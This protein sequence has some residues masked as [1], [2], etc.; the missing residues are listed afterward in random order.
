MSNIMK[1]IIIV[2]FRPCKQ[3]FLSGMCL[4][5]SV[6]TGCSNDKEDLPP[7]PV[8]YT[9]LIYMIA[10]NSMDSDVDYSIS[11][12]KAGARHS[13]GTAVVYVDRLNE[14]PRLFKITQA[15]EEVPLKSYAEDNSANIETLVEVIEETKK[16][17]P[18]EKFGLV[19][20]S[21]SMGWLPNGYSSGLRMTRGKAEQDFP[22]TRYIGPDFHPGDVPTSDNMIEVDEL[23]E[24][25]PD[26]V[27]EYIWFDVCLMGCVEGL[28]AVRNKC[29]YLIASP[30][31]V[32]AEADYDASGIPYAKVL[33]YMF[34]GAEELKQACRADYNHYNGMKYDV[35]RSATITLVDAKQLDGLYD[36]VHGILG[37]HLSEVE[38]MDT[39]GLQAYHTKDVPG[40]FFDLK[41][42]VN[43]LKSTD[44]AIL[45]AQLEKTVVYTEATVSFKNVAIDRNR[46]C[47]LSVYVPL[48]KWE[49]NA[50]Y[51]YYFESLEWGRIYD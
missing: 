26:H 2:F 41:D 44:D 30:T 34:G 17:V 50:E 15:G 36:V 11:Q 3:L 12:L 32:L 9:A 5:L 6:F 14:A 37:G 27:A 22:R 20:W 33:P 48:R 45:E 10:D 4:L 16:L 46:Y 25:L 8:S 23:A 35:L 40:V 29:N 7:A 31:E 28:Y 1:P 43:R 13:A 51:K 19:L 39:S 24:S 47:G 18:S 38:S 49:K 21:H 42:M